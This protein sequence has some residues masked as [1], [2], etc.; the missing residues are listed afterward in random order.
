MMATDF[1]RYIRTVMDADCLAKFLEEDNIHYIVAVGDITSERYQ[2]WF[3]KLPNMIVI[4]GFGEGKYPTQIYQDVKDR[5]D[6]TVVMPKGLMSCEL[7]DF[8][9]NK[10]TFQEDC[11]I[12]V[13]GEEDYAFLPA[14][15]F[16]NENTAVIAGDPKDKRMIYMKGGL[17]ARTFA[18]TEIISK[19]DAEQ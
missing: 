12:R 16:A 3:G 2:E 19:G 13:V 5:I 10:M 6:F 14:L 7:L 15:L 17:E 11:V 8:M 9:F 4:D 18:W 1:N